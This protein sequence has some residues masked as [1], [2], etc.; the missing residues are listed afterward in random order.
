MS[1]CDFEDDGNII[2]DSVVA[3][4]SD[5]SGRAASAVA[6]A[7][8]I[9][10]ARAARGLQSAACVRA[11]KVSRAAC[12]QPRAPRA[13]APPRCWARVARRPT[14][15]WRNPAPLVPVARHP[16]FAAN[17]QGNTGPA[18]RSAQRGCCSVRVRRRHPTPRVRRRRPRPPPP[19]CC[20]MWLTSRLYFCSLSASYRR[21]SETLDPLL[22]ACAESPARVN[23]RRPP[24]SPLHPD[25]CAEMRRQIVFLQ[26]IDSGVTLRKSPSMK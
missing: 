18:Y 2:G 20:R 3:T 15:M 26:V 1:H 22:A 12:D 5:F 8:P 17:A 13:P 16:A 21:H 23:G 9:P 7:A 11:V 25:A 6:A 19:C 4:R 24:A 14:S 10:I